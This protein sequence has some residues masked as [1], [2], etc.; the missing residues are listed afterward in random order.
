MAT[1]IT[2]VSHQVE[3]VGGD[4]PKMLN[5]HR[6]A[7]LGQGRH[8][9]GFVL[10]AAFHLRKSFPIVGNRKVSEFVLLCDGCPVVRRGVVLE[11]KIKEM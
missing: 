8:S 7:H 5:A 4:R 3:L 1:K 11:I 9:E 2:Q 6:L 10:N